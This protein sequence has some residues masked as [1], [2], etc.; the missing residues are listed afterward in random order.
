MKL[1]NIAFGLV[2]L[3]AR[4][5]AGQTLPPGAAALPAC[6]QITV[7]KEVRSLNPTEWQAYANAVAA[8]YTD[9]WID[10]FG[11]YHNLVASNVHGNSNFLVFHRHYINSYEAIL[12]SYN[13]AI[14]IPYWN[15]MIDYQK[16]D[17]SAVLGSSY[18]GGDGTGSKNCVTTGIAGTWTL[19]YPKSHCLCRNFNNGTTINSWYSPEYITS[20]L[21]K[22]A[23]YADLRAGIENSIHGAVHLG[24][25]GDMDTMHSPSDPV[26]FLHHVN[27]DRLYAQW[28]AVKPDSRT[29]MYDG[30]GVNNAPVA[31]TDFIRGTSTPVSAVMRLGYGDMCYTYDT[32]K[33]ANGDA[34]ALV[35]RQSKCIAR[36][37]QATEQI[38]QLPPKVLEKFYPSF[39]NGAASPLE[40]EMLSLHPLQP[41]G[42]D[43]R[44][45]LF[46]IPAPSERMRGKMPHPSKLSDEWIKM[47]GTSVAEVKAMEQAACDMVD[48]L[49]KANYLSPYLF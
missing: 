13:P 11:F 22:S 28:Q 44:A 35:K 16:P 23:T 36:P 41:M 1:L 33:A 8:A 43:P 42:A 6:A 29:Y 47:Q 46:K 17:K 18:L 39:A 26:F 9:K 24:I 25:G 48:A 7:R 4:G 32:I 20:V 19:S 10:W 2:L 45:P 21:Q 12:R 31:I 15:A 38:K 14:S 37:N 40:N 5:T 27:I 3:G 30:T 49:N 34:S